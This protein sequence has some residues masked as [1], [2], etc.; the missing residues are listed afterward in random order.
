MVKMVFCFTKEDKSG[1]ELRSEDIKGLVKV[2][3]GFKPLAPVEVKP[4]DKLATSAGKGIRDNSAPVGQVQNAAGRVSM[5][6]TPKPAVAVVQKHW[7][8]TGW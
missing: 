7:L 6:D 1:T 2:G 3:N 5:H 8:A 4:A